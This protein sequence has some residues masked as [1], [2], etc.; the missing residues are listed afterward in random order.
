MGVPAVGDFG[1]GSGIF[2][3]VPV[4]CE[5]GGEVMRVGGVSLTP[6]VRAGG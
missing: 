3:S 4:I 2:Y 1:T 6:E 5:E